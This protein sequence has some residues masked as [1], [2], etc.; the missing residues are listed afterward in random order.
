MV[1]L[2]F[3]VLELTTDIFFKLF[4]GDPGYATTVF[5][6]SHARDTVVV[7][8]DSAAVLFVVEPLACVY[9]AV[10]PLEGALTLLD[11]I[12]EFA[13]VLAS[14]GPCHLAITVHLIF[15]PLPN[16]FAAVGPRV[17]SLSVDLVVEPE[18][19]VG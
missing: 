3:L 17:L 7:G 16:V 2:V 15:F 13:F 18:A 4:L 6:D 1:V 8:D 9:A 12:E 14:I 5:P 19:I 11:V 10:C